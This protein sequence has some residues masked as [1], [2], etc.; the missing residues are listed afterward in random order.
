MVETNL[1]PELGLANGSTGLIRDIVYRT[2]ELPPTNLPKFCW[3]EMADYAGPTFF[4]ENESR[5][6]WV[7][8]YPITG[9]DYSV[10]GKSLSRTMLP[11]RLAWAWTIWKAQGQTIRGKVVIKL[12][13][14][15]REHGL[16][17]VAFSRATRLSNIGI[18]GGMDG[19]RLTSAISKLKKLKNRVKEDERLDSL[20]AKTIEKLDN[21]RNGS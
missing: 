4:P 6:Q 20:Y 13:K 12:G 1:C 9:E 18:I 5:K 7:P 2:N 11:L 14:S 8:I 16:S 19:P 3:V 21:L 15:E 17:Y 10:A